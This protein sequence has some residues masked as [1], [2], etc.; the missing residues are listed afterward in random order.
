MSRTEVVL[1]SGKR[2]PTGGPGTASN[3]P[4]C[5]S[6]IETFNIQTQHRAIFSVKVYTAYLN[7]GVGSYHHPMCAPGVGV[8]WVRRLLCA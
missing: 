5:Y 4:L 6:N 3:N 2:I 8:S 1:T 7:S